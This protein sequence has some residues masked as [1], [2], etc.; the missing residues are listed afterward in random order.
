MQ[1]AGVSYPALAARG[2]LA[3]TLVLTAGARAHALDAARTLTQYVHRIWQVTQGLPQASI[4]A[5]VQTSDGRL[6]LGTQT[7]LV[8]FDGVRFTTIDEVNGVSMADVWVT[9]LI[10]DHQHALW[11]GTD[12]SGVFRL[13]DGV[14]TRFSKPEGLPSDAVQC[15][16][17]DHGGHVWACTANGLATWDGHAFQTFAPPA[18]PA[19]GNVAAACETP[20]RHLWIAHDGRM[21]DTWS[22]GRYA[23]RSIAMSRS[24]AIRTVMCTSSGD[25]WVGTTDGVF[26]VRGDREHHLTTADHLADNSVLTLA[27][28]RDSA[29]LVG[30]SNG[31]SRIRGRDVES[32]RAQDG[33]SQSAVYALYEDHEGTLWVATGHGLNQF[34]DGRAT[35]YTTSEGLP[36]N[37]TGPVVEDHAGTIWTGTLGAGLARFDDHRFSTLTTGDGLASNS[38]LAIA[39]DQ[40]GNLW[41][42]TDRGLNRVHDRRVDGTWTTARGLPADTVRALIVD[43]SGALW[44]GTTRGAA[45]YRHGIIERIAGSNASITA[46]G[47]DNDGR[48]YIAPRDGSLQTYSAGALR[49]VADDQLALRHV[50]AMYTD[51]AGVVWIGTAGDGLLAIDHGRISRYSVRDGLFDDSIYA[52]LGDDHGRLWMAC[53]KG[54]FSVDRAQL[55]RFAPD[56]THKVISTPYSPTDVLRTI[57][58]KPGVQP[59]AWSGS[60]GQLWFSTTRGLLVLDS[61]NAD[62]RFEAPPAAIEEITVNGERTSST[63]GIGTLPPGRNNVAFRYT[64]LSFVV[65]TRITFKYTLEGFDTKWVDAGTRR[66]AFYTNLPPG[67]F[68][69][70]VSAC[71]LD[72]ECHEAASAVAFV[73]EPRYYQHAWFIPLCIVGAALIGLTGYRLRIRRLREHFDLVLAERSRIARELHDTLI[74]GFSGITMAMQALAARL[75]ATQDQRALEQ[76]VS[77]AGTS[78]REARRSLSGLRSRPAAGSGLADAIAQTSRQLTEARGIRLKLRLDNWDRT[79]PPEVED[80]LLRIA[81]E[82]VLNAVK[83]SG[84]RSLLVA[85]ERTANRVRLV[86]KDDGSGFDGQTAAAQAGHYGVLGMRERAAHIGAELSLDSAPGNGTAVSVT[87]DA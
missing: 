19:L 5:V 61:K 34:L 21:L 57:E 50:D 70:R 60:G 81:Q 7:G 18:H 65:P 73:V 64:G 42:G 46:L 63:S 49:N 28:S 29:V 85:L 71:N 82:A 67:H 15:L 44:I 62:R 78:L 80:N 45:V 23:E 3:L 69:F 37:D 31:F 58:C 75:P 52:I 24:G 66:E 11:I 48:I 86:I 4:Y 25:V 14:L 74:Q 17:E 56:Q 27:E 20:D 6:W 83:H 30:T 32:F 47:A 26:Q 9:E 16:F 35:P 55:L 10:E 39:E 38:V 2:L 43:T 76:I 13:Q 33:L 53:S 77:D 87:M 36:S 51:K 22:N 40:A 68:R 79:L 72:G 8:R 84:A 54:I 12:A 41:V 59:A 1:R